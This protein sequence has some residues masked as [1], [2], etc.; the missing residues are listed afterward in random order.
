MAS[1]QRLQNTLMM[2]EKCCF[3]NN[4]WVSTRLWICLCFSELCRKSNRRWFKR[5]RCWDTRA[6]CPSTLCHAV[7]MST[8]GAALCPC[9][10]L[11]LISLERPPSKLQTHC[12]AW[13]TDWLS[14]SKDTHSLGSLFPELNKKSKQNLQKHIIVPLAVQQY[15]KAFLVQNNQSN[16]NLGYIYI[17]LI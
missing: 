5:R 3:P 13:S 7:P 1:L 4:P 17:V 9:K 8:K 11:G 2:A 10:K 15:L 14:V 6:V 16:H 12:C